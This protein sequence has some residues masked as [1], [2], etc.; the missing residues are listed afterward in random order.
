MD[1][2]D[3]FKRRREKLK[4]M[5]KHDL[6]LCPDSE[7]I[8]KFRNSAVDYDSIHSIKAS[9]ESYYDVKPD[10]DV[11][12]EEIYQ[13]LEEIS[14]KF[15]DE[16]FNMLLIEC[17]KTVIQS[18]VNPFGLGAFVATF[19]K[20]GGN[21]DTIHN[22]RSG[23]YVTDS[24][25][26]KYDLRGEYNSNCYHS[27]TRYIQRNRDDTLKQKSGKLKDG[28]T[29]NTLDIRSHRDLDHIISAKEIHDDPGR[30]LAEIDG[31]ELAN[32]RE[33]LISTERIINR[34]KK[35]KPMREFLEYL[36]NTKEQ[37]YDEIRRLKSKPFLTD[38]EKKRLIK[39]ERLNSVNPS[40]CIEKDEKARKVYN[41]KIN[42]EYYTSYKFYRNTLTTSIGEGSKLGMQQAIGLLLVEFFSGVFHEIS[43]LYHNGF[44]IDNAGFATS[45]KIRLNRL[46]ERINSRWKDVCDVFA[47]GFVSGFLSN[48]ATTVINT[49]ITTGKRIVRIIREG[50]F[51]LL[52][53]IKLLCIP[54]EG[55][56]FAEA[57]H[58]A[59][60]LIASG[61]VI[62]AGII[63]EHGIDAWIKATV[64][65]A[66][67][68]DLVTTIVV[69]ALT[70]IAVTFVVYAIDKLD[71]FKVRHIRKLD[72]VLEELEIKINE[73]LCES[74]ELIKQMAWTI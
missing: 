72:F 49:F 11:S 53:A 43:D 39:L 56:T 33:N 29:D 64:I 3:R 37:R 27:D 48:L 2:V 31:P 7:I 9:F 28:Y 45:L 51:S 42:V 30:I 23:V 35:A 50:F 61:L 46:I 4:D 18:I 58:E 54:P 68:S 34:A 15:D 5:N 41:R 47:Q 52:R 70:G 65:L 22:V 32:V 44:R 74:E 36:H 63:I 62:G 10:L 38:E 60:K 6:Y 26:E 71:F 20:T 67:I 24:E 21:V 25:K 73:A 57:A 8:D 14:D 1:A 69:G 40:L 13:L 59:S 55:M 12:E 16:T 19:D 17:S 66:P